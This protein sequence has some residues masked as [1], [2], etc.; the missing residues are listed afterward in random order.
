ME[1]TLA[2]HTVSTEVLDQP[3]KTVIV[4]YH[5]GCM[6]GWAA[7][8]IVY[9]YFRGRRKVADSEGPEPRMFA[10]PSGGD[11]PN[12]LELE[13]NPVIIVLDMA[14]PAETMI[15]LINAAHRMVWID[16]H[17]TAAPIRDAMLTGMRFC[18][19]SNRPDFGQVEDYESL[20]KGKRNR[21]SYIFNTKH[22]AAVLTWTYFYP[23]RETPD[24]IKYVEDRDL[25]T[26]ALPYSKQVNAAI[27]CLPLDFGLWGHYLFD[28]PIEVHQRMLAISG[29]HILSHISQTVA[30]LAQS[31]LV[32]HVTVSVT[33]TD[34]W[35]G[36]V[37]FVN[38][39]CY[40]SEIGHE[41]LTLHPKA[42]FAVVWYQRGNGESV[43]EL[44][45]ADDRH[46]VA[47]IA[48]VL[49]GGGHRNAAGFVCNSFPQPSALA[50]G[51]IHWEAV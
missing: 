22:S 37:P 40:C 36:D 31:A 46:D 9:S 27:R 4:F 14:F 2:S 11:L 35:F 34:M 26:W 49:G 43:Y 33:D 17:E 51:T 15:K 6:D 41:L 12:D 18:G 48:K 3:P 16:H 50:K 42:P 10:I 19:A 30:K 20:G 8:S 47:Y 21:L 13:G 23:D 32:Y 24:L 5:G 44:R 28:N 7:A 1:A 29:S 45:S 25:W 39:H 38:S